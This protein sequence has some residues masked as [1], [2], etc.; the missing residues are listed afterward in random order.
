MASSS[1]YGE[2]PPLQGYRRSFTAP[3]RQLSYHERA[4]LDKSDADSGVVYEH[5]HVRI[6]SFAPPNESIVSRNSETHADADYPIDTIETLPWRSRTEDLT[7]TGPMRIEK[8]QGSVNFLKCGHNFVHSILRNSQ[9]WCVDGESKF[10]LRKRKLEYYRIELPKETT[11]ERAKVEELKTVLATVLKYEK[12]PCPFKRAFQV[13]LPDDAITP[14]RKGKWKARDSSL[15]SSPDLNTPSV[16]K[17]KSSRPSMPYTPPSAFPDSFNKRRT[18]E[19]VPDSPITPM[20]APVQRRSSVAERRAA[21]EHMQSSSRPS[22]RPPSR[23]QTPTSTSS[24]HSFED[25]GSS[26]RDRSIEE[27]DSVLESADLEDDGSHPLNGNARVPSPLINETSLHTDNEAEP[28]REVEIEPTNT[29]EETDEVFLPEYHEEVAPGEGSAMVADS[30]GPILDMAEDEGITDVNEPLPDQE[31]IIDAPN[32]DVQEETTQQEPAAFEEE[33]EPVPSNNT[34]TEAPTT[35]AEASVLDETASIASTADSF[36]STDDIPDHIP[37]VDPTPLA[38]DHDPFASKQYS[39]KRDISELTVT[40]S[41]FSEQA[42]SDPPITPRLIQSSMSDQSWPD[43]QTPSSYLQDGLRQ[44]QKGA[45]S[46]SPMPSSHILAPSSSDQRQPSPARFSATVI[47]KAATIAVTKPL[48]VVVLVVQ[49]LAR[50]AGGAT[51]NDLLNG[52]LFQQPPQRTTRQHNRN[53]SFPDRVVAQ[54]DDE[55]EDDFGVPIRIRTR[56][57]EQRGVPQGGFVPVKEERERDEDVD[58]LFA[59]DLD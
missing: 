33:A 55:E 45:R 44:R 10:V 34:D 7:A 11:E 46:L 51:L 40:A 31:H 23:P 9:C 26:D 28:E 48:E 52:G 25:D 3:H 30:Q 57:W 16:R 15:L 22:S 47:Q 4:A 12:T 5:P 59:D 32:K 17:W 41:T 53:P 42:D 20:S 37:D 49:I 43:I 19:F 2:R 13:E 6:I 56:S 54:S 38:R 58:S 8:V 29:S 39:H 1:A 36:H 21:F 35:E 27:T 18:S 14:R 50:I 24:G